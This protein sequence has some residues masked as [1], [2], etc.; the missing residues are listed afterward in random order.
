ME[1][2]VLLKTLILSRSLPI[3]AARTGLIMLEYRVLHHNKGPNFGKST[4]SLCIKQLE[5]SSLTWYN[6]KQRIPWALLIVLC[7]YS[8]CSPSYSEISNLVAAF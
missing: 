1:E 5:F 6:P 7:I 8:I 3:L 4:I 2:A